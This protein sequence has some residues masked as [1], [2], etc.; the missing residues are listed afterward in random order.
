M[1]QTK[2]A[3]DGVR[4]L[5]LSR[6]IAGPWS[7]QILGDLGAK[8]TKIEHPEKGDDTRKWGPPF[9]ESKDGNKSDGAYYLCANRNK[10]IKAIDLK[11]R[12]GQEQI[13]AMARESHILAENFQ[14]GKLSEY[15]LGYSEIKKIN[16]SIVYCSVTGFGQ[17]GPYKDRPGYDYLVQAM[18][19][20]LQVTGPPEQPYKVGVAAADLFT[21]MYATVGIL[22]A[23]RHAER[24]GEGQHVDVCLLDCQI[25]MLSN[26]AS[27]YLVTGEEPI[28]TGNQHPSITPYQP[29]DTAD[30]PILLAVGNDSQFSRLSVLLGV[31][32]HNDPRFAESGPRSENRDIL[33]TELSEIL[34]QNPAAHWVK[35]FG[36]ANI[37]C[38]PVNSVGD[39]LKDP[40]VKERQMIVPFC[41][42]DGT[43]F[44][45]VGSPIKLS[46]TPVTYRQA[47][48]K[49]PKREY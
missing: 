24:T 23:L 18:G 48:Q 38:G 40:H 31:S 5:D 7:T 42:P 39:I 26:Q 22:G 10:T 16:P 1:T 14:V 30:K 33:L 41:R 12:Q 36:D 15:G 27:N 37:P 43:Q 46:E 25:A 29:F 47:P 19:G 20:L 21:G 3:L 32:W 6:V 28:R 8:V 45:V 44:S 4:V 49:H 11:T 34:L 17:T 9:L 2:G 13:K 35:V